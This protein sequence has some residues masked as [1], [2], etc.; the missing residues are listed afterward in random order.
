[1]GD[2]LHC[3]WRKARHVGASTGVNSSNRWLIGIGATLIA[4]VA[5]TLVVVFAGDRRATVFAADTPEGSVQRYLQAL[6]DDDLTAAYGYLS[7]ELRD[8]CAPAQWRESARYSKPELTQGL[9]LLT[10]VRKVSNDSEIL[11]EV[12]FRRFAEPG[13]LPLPPREQSYTRP[14][15][16]SA[17][18]DGTWRFVEQPWPNPWACPPE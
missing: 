5:V 1:M 17:G 7:P 11:V 10:D 16:L 13:L 15:V 12:T 4:L 9:V 14:F 8:A 6:A 2:V 3:F 18:E